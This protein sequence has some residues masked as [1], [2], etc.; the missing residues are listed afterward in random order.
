MTVGKLGILN[1]FWCRKYY[2]I[3]MVN[4]ETGEMSMYQGIERTPVALQAV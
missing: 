2:P 1:I 4:P 3:H